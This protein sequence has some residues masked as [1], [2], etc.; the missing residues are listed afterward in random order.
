MTEIKNPF[1][2]KEEICFGRKDENSCNNDLAC[3]WCVSAAVK[4]ACH[5][6]GNA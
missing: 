6:I 3:S 5:S 1:K 4:P 2:G